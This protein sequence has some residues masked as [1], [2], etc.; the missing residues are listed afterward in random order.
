MLNELNSTNNNCKFVTKV[1]YFPFGPWWGYDINIFSFQDRYATFT[2]GLGLN[3]VKGQ[4]SLE[5]CEVCINYNP[6]FCTS[7]Y[8]PGVV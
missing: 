6:S 1:K 5:E 3:I 4:A 7:I 2:D 8:Q